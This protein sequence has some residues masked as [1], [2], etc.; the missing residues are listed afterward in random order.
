MMN[1]FQNNSRISTEL[2][3]ENTLSHH[4]IYSSSNNDNNDDNFNGN[5]TLKCVLEISKLKIDDEILKFFSPN[6]NLSKENCCICL[7][8]ID[9]KKIILSGCKHT[10]H[11]G[12]AKK[13]FMEKAHCPL[14]RS[15]QNRLKNRICSMN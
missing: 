3:N 14:C 1:F 8:K 6:K 4:P 15:N 13:W 12:C 10:L 2:N 9:T 11:I 7:E 5:E